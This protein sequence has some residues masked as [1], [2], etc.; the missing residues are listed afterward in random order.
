M[1]HAAAVGAFVASGGDHVKRL[2]AGW[3]QILQNGNDSGNDVTTFLD[4]D[5]VSV[6]L[7]GNFFIG[8]Y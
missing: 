7:V 6:G 2:G 8:K 3:P 4:D 1:D 5:R